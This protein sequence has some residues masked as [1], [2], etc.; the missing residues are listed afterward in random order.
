MGMNSDDWKRVQE[1]VE[2]CLRRV[3]RERQP[4]PA[5]DIDW[6][7]AGLLDSM[8]HVEVLSTIE[9]ATGI[10]RLFQ[11]SGAAPATIHAVV[12][13]ICEAQSERAQRADE[14]A[15]SDP[16]ERSRDRPIIS[17]WFAQFGSTVVPAAV[18]EREFG[19]APGTMA[20]RAGIES[21]RRVSAEEDIL[22]LALGAAD[23]AI[24][25]AGISPRQ[26]DWILA[27]S[28]TWRRIPSL[29]VA[30]HGALLVPETCRVLDLGGECA[31]ALDALIAADSLL[32]GTR[33]K[34]ALVV[35]AD[36]HSRVFS[37]G[38]V[39]GELAGLFGDG[40]GAFVMSRSTDNAAPGVRLLADTGGCLGLYSGALK[41]DMGPQG[42]LEIKFDGRSLSE[43]ALATM[44]RGIGELELITGINRSA[45]AAF[46]LHQPNPRLLE[47]FI[48]QAN[49][50][51]DKVAVISKTTGNLGASTCGAA[52]CAALDRVMGSEAASSAPV[53]A[54][55][56]RP[57]IA[58]TAAA[59][60]LTGRPESRGA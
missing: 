33:A 7:E 11:D 26:L 24:R 2:R 13:A 53:F 14:F 16:G 5:E 59:F 54:V 60:D 20:V 25:K 38:Q 50:P 4:L 23:G 55:A 10:N 30:L 22:S 40:A 45:V 47:I 18:V 46:A 41:I 49:L 56:V 36:A 37:P 21:V 48:R 43:A 42:S 9:I 1:I 58:W 17:G 35:S 44:E 3:L 57:G 8:A 51:A 28:E 34:C 19:L 29:G 39:P 6:L 32:S 12:A 27:T 52:L 15:G 31:G